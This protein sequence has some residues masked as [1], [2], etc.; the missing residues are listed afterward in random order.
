MSDDFYNV[1]TCTTLEDIRRIKAE[2][3]DNLLYLISY[4]RFSAIFNF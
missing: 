4:V 1:F 3:P 2:K